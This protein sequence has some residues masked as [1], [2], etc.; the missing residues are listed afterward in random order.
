[1]NVLLPL[2]VAAVAAHGFTV[3]VLRRSIL[4][5]KISRRGHHLT[6]D[7]AIDPLEMAFVRDAMRRD[8]V[9][10]PAGATLEEAG[11]RLPSAL[12][13][14]RQRLYPVVAADQRLIG[15][16][17]RTQLRQALAHPAAAGSRLTVE[18]LATRGPVVAY[19]DETLRVVVYRMAESGLTRLPVVER[20][21]APMVVGLIALTDLLQARVRH[22]HEEGRRERVLGK[23]MRLPSRWRRTGRPIAVDGA[24][25]PA[26]DAADTAL[27][28]AGAGSS[29]D[30]P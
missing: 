19:P 25:P 26:G 8:V 24:S 15:V 14:R 4:T 2:L 1:M 29:R 7:Y 5:E 22:L 12:S 17:T 9:V 16:V 28:G 30:T 13:R 27:A 21:P 10:L 18:T 11:H 3:L 20:G 23:S 6:R